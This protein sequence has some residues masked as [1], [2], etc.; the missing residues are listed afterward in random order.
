M[1]NAYSELYLD[2]SQDILGQAFDWVVNTCEDDLE[3]FCN[4]FSQSRIAAMFEIGYPK[5]VAGCNGAELVNFVMEDLGLPE[6]SCPQ[7]FFADR[8]PEYWAGWVLAYFQWWVNLPFSTILHQ[9]PVAKIISLYPLG[10]EQDIR[11]IVDILSE[12]VAPRSKPE[13][14][15]PTFADYISSD[16]R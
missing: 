12:S 11:N 4:R 13:G 9:I 16:D 6:Y 2:S 5:Y 15:L 8:S 3:T 1:I 14:S 7:E 10:H